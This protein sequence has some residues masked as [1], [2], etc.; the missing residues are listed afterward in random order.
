MNKLDAYLDA[1]EAIDLISRQQDRPEPMYAFNHIFTQESVYQS[2]LRSERRRLH[3]QIGEAME[4]LYFASPDIPER[5]RE[6]LA[7]VLARHFQLSGDTARAL[8]YLKMAGDRANREYANQEARDFYSQALQL[9]PEK[10][11]RQRWEIL[12]GR[13]QVLDRLGAR[14]DQVA[15]LTNMQL[16]AEILQDEASLSETHNRRA[17][18]FDKVSEYQDAASAAEAGWQLARRS[19]DPRLQARSLNLLALSA[20]RRFDYE[21]VKKWANQALD[22]LRVAGIPE[23]RLVSLLLLGRASYRLGQFDA[24]LEYVQAARTLAAQ[25]GDVENEI[26]SELILGWIFQ[27]L[28]DP[29]TAARHYQKVL[30]MR[31]E[32]GDRP[33]EAIALSH[34]GWLACDQGRYADG[35]ALCRQAAELSRSVGDLE[36]EAYALTGLGLNAE[37]GGDTGTAEE[38]YR[39]AL[40]IQEKI[41]AV[42]LATFN[43]VRLAWLYARQNQPALARQYLEPVID[44][45][46]AGHGQQFWDPWAIYLTAYRTLLSLG[47][48][49]KARSVLEEAYRLLHQRAEKIGDAEIKRRFL[50]EAASSREI[51]QAWRQTERPDTRKSGP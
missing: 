41:G 46:R 15:D 27:R 8:K 42:P 21:A 28:G 17:S 4:A 48:D 16:L 5:K 23:E 32:I 12:A 18:Y 10:E 6:E 3:Q 44:W 30:N 34:L 14:E 24:A 49:G 36:N 26:S 50:T 43:R 33:G 35:L 13:E 2:L 1:L 9:L 22:A 11:Y 31:Q 51:I 25:T 7:P 45:I 38:A 47:E 37:A 40:A 19:G 29:Q 39:Q 20:W